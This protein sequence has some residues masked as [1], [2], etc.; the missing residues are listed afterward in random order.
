MHFFTLIVS[1]IEIQRHTQTH[2]INIILKKY[3]F[4]TQVSKILLF[5]LIIHKSKRCVYSS[6]KCNTI[7]KQQKKKTKILKL[8]RKGKNKASRNKAN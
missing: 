3:A 8:Y 6:K 7:N 1:K 4:R 5:S 2:S